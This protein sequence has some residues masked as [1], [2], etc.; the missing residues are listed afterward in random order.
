MSRASAFLHAA[1][2][3]A[4]GA[5]R[6]CEQTAFK[7]APEQLLRVYARRCG[8]V[9]SGRP[10]PRLLSAPIHFELLKAEAHACGWVC[11]PPPGLP[12]PDAALA[13][14]GRQTLPSTPRSRLM[15]PC[16]LCL[17]PLFAP[18]APHIP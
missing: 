12:W 18:T 7:R 2:T 5:P 15:R 11:T 9:T 14:V 3:C 16:F 17:V 4:E 8:G 1:L 10:G 13:P 6:R